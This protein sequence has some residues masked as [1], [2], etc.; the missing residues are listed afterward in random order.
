MALIFTLFLSFY[1]FLSF[2]ILIYLICKTYLLRLIIFLLSFLLYRFKSLS[3]SIQ[4]ILYSLYV[5]ILSIFIYK[6]SKIYIKMSKKYICPYILFYIYI[7]YIFLY[8]ARNSYNFMFFLLSSIFENM[9]F[10]KNKNVQK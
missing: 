9:T 5:S 7:Y 1:Y 3:K 8:I 4:S 6:M 10:Q 2:S